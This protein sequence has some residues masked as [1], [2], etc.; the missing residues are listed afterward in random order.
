[1]INEA[2]CQSDLLLTLMDM[3]ELQGYHHSTGASLLRKESHP[4]FIYNFSNPTLDFRMRYGDEVKGKMDPLAISYRDLLVNLHRDKKLLP[5]TDLQLASLEYAPRSDKSEE[6]I[7]KELVEL[8]ELY[9]VSLNQNV[10]DKTIEY[11]AKNF[12]GLGVFTLKGNYLVTDDG[13]LTLIDCCKELVQLELAECLLLSQRSM[14]KALQIPTLMIL[15]LEGMDVLNDKLLEKIDFKSEQLCSISLVNSS[16]KDLSKFSRMFPS[17][18]SAN[19][20][21]SKID[22]ESLIAF[23]KSQRLTTLCLYECESMDDPTLLTITAASK[24]LGA[25]TLNDCYSITDKGF[26]QFNHPKVETLSLK[27]PTSLT[28]KGL[29]SLMKI[30]LKNLLIQDAVSLTKEGMKKARLSSPSY[31]QLKVDGGTCF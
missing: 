17:L 5:E 14:I 8:D 18:N 20:S 4:I 6:E 10:T 19:F 9:S 16:I 12:P 7:L 23:L 13:L 2:G 28:D 1:M 30:P 24:N 11:I 31:V 21:F 15:A 25:L 22:K 29:E 3:L 26:A 27:A